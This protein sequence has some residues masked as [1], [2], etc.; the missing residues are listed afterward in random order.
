MKGK[1]GGGIL[2]FFCLWNVINIPFLLFFRGRVFLVLGKAF[3][4][5]AL[6]LSCLIIPIFALTLFFSLGL[7]V[8]L[9]D[10]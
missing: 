4:R 7:L 5:P 9:L 6:M 2:H 1:L 8:R 3:I 10:T